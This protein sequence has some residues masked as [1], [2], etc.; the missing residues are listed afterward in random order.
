MTPSP[1]DDPITSRCNV[2]PRD[3]SVGP[4]LVNSLDIHIEETPLNP[5]NL[6]SLLSLDSNSST[7]AHSPPKPKFLPTSQ[8]EGRIS[9]QPHLWHQH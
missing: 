2:Q 9:L 4:E 6:T 3:P 8:S 5:I 7:Q 1:P